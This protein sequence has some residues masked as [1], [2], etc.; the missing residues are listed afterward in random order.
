MYIYSITCA[1]FVCLLGEL[2]N[3]L[4]KLNEELVE[5]TNNSDLELDSILSNK[6]QGDISQNIDDTLNDDEFI[7][8][9][10]DL[11]VQ[12]SQNC[13]TSDLYISS[14]ANTVSEGNSILLKYRVLIKKKFKY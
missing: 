12:P 11:I 6:L 10:N 14:D 13:S 9:M 3:G 4:E 5:S 8:K 1:A 7:L 2:S